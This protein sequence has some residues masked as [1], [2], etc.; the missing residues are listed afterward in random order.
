VFEREF[1]S[2]TP[3]TGVGA[4]NGAGYAGYSPNSLNN[5]TSTDN[6]RLTYPDIAS[7]GVVGT[8]L[9]TIASTT[10]LSVGD[11]VL[12]SGIPANAKVASIIDGTQFTIDTT[13]GT[14]NPTLNLPK[15][16]ALT[17]NRTINSL[18]MIVSG[19]STLDLGGNTLNLTSG[20]LIASQGFNLAGAQV[21]VV[22]SS[23]SSNI[24]E[25]A[26]VPQ[27]LVVGSTLLGRNVT[28]IN[29]LNVTLDG[30]ANAATSSPT[31][32]DYLSALN[33][34]IEIQNGNLT[35]GG[36]LNTAA[37]LY[38]HA[39][40]YANGLANVYNRDVIVSSN[41]V[42]ACFEWSRGTGQLCGRQ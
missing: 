30:N 36:V 33:M 32:R 9:L 6:I 24:I 21:T 3:G 23:T 13:L 34:P 27:S 29:G 10:G 31:L 20:G 38:I 35:A 40:G 37:D 12:G 28:S 14:A 26:S 5:G 4:L 17:G 39:L 22:N 41:I 25:V 18:A 42:D 19:D 8:N 16:V 1:A 2:Y 15:T 11:A 7:A